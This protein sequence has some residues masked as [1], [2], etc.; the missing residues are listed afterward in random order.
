MKLLFAL[1]TLAAA[2][3][4]ASCSCTEEDGV[5]EE[6][7]GIL[8]AD[9]MD[10]DWQQNWFL[11]GKKA[12]VEHRDG[13]LFFSGGT[14]T[15]A[16][17]REAYHAHH[18]VLWTKQEFRGDIRLSFETQQVDL[19]GYGNVLIY[20]QAQ[21]IGTPPYA[22]DIT[23]WNELRDVPAMNMYFNTMNLISVSLRKELRCKRYPFTD[24][25]TGTQYE[26]L[27]EPMQDWHGVQ[28]GRWFRFVIDK[29]RETLRFRSYDVETGEQLSDFTWD[30]TKVSD[31]LTPRLVE[32][33]RIG[34]R[35]MSTKQSLYRNFV[36]S[37]L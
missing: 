3:L 1:G 18:A 2:V 10:A 14:V 22:E 29:R 23:D 9:P 8:F 36:V 33:G 34:L 32:G 17:D 25:A 12:T 4:L 37:E 26:P 13:A 30:T 7:Q 11:D 20:I 28:P 15:K 16:M 21:G 19:S 6:K 5:S 24:V 35:H 31:R 27:F